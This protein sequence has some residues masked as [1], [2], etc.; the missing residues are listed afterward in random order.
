METT[1]RREEVDF[2]IKD[3][4]VK[5]Y[6]I[7]DMPDFK[8]NGRLGRRT[9]G[10][11][12][13]SGIHAGTIEIAKNFR[14]LERAIS[15]LLHEAVHYALHLLDRDFHD[16]EYEFEKELI[17]YDLPTNYGKDFFVRKFKESR[18]QLRGKYLVK[19]MVTYYADIINEKREQEQGIKKIEKVANIKVKEGVKLEKTKISIMLHDFKMNNLIKGTNEYKLLTSVVDAI[20]NTPAKNKEGI[21]KIYED[22][23][24][25]Y[26]E[27]RFKDD[28]NIYNLVGKGLNDVLVL[29]NTKIDN[30]DI[31]GIITGLRLQGQL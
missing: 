7:M 2:I 4:L 17:K 31:S 6:K 22:F 5:Q 12:F 1:I 15:T 18:I 21:V 14:T 13:H 19:D 20:D 27:D 10:Q 29:M 9:L 26:I 24:N 16:G 11:Y 28:K 23:L 25:T 3:F 8:F 30:D